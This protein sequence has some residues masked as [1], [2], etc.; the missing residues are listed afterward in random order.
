MLSSVL[1]VGGWTESGVSTPLEDDVRSNFLKLRE[2]GRKKVCD[3]LMSS[4]TFNLHQMTSLSS[5]AT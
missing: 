5:T 3:G 1:E 2:S 4:Q